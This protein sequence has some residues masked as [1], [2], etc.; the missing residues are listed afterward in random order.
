[1]PKLTTKQRKELP[2]SEYGLPKRRAFPLVD[3]NHVRLAIRF[4]NSASDE[5]K[6]ILAKNIN[7]KAKEFGIKVNPKNQTLRKYLSKEVLGN[8]SEGYSF[9][10]DAFNIGTLSPIVPPNQNLTLSE[11]CNKDDELALDVVEDKIDLGFSKPNQK[12]KPIFENMYKRKT[13]INKKQLNAIIDKIIR[14]EEFR[15]LQLYVT[16]SNCSSL[17]DNS[18]KNMNDDLMLSLRDIVNEELYKYFHGESNID[19]IISQINLSRD[20]KQM[21]TILLSIYKLYSLPNTENDESIFYKIISK[22]HD[23]DIIFKLIRLSQVDRLALNK[24]NFYESYVLGKKKPYSNMKNIPGMLVYDFYNNDTLFNTI[25]KQYHTEYLKYVKYRKEYDG[26]LD[27]YAAS[28]FEANIQLLTDNDDNCG[29]LYDNKVKCK[30]IF[31]NSGVL[32]VYRNGMIYKP[33]N[34]DIYYFGHWYL[35]TYSS[36]VKYPIFICI[37]IAEKVPYTN[38]VEYYDYTKISDSIRVF[39][40]NWSLHKIDQLTDKDVT[41]ES[42]SHIK[43][44]FYKGLDFIK[45]IELMDNGDITINLDD[46]L[47]FEHYNQVHKVIKENDSNGNYEAV[48]ENLAY[49][50]SIILLIED[51]YMDKHTSKVNKYSKEYDD[52]VRLRALYINDFKLYLSHVTRDDRNF[53]FLEYYK[54]SRANNSV[55]RIRKSTISRLSLLFKTIMFS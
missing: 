8:I 35:K 1:M 47:T 31:T 48:K 24:S 4:F 17:S 18:F 2:N 54:H 55:Y 50:F 33:T 15:E 22:I 34:E 51:R 7:K 10:T 44:Y 42:V 40:Y 43:N 3:A 32:D 53:N 19:R 20:E 16:K 25:Q 5:E 28:Y 52:A 46:K 41:V 39:N 27:S 36:T 13:I 26:N 45:N 29:Y 23:P 9:I 14:D 49:I 30:P 21:K 37:P 38:K 6:P 12:P 11:D